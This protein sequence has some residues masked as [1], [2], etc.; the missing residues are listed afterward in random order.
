M[1]HETFEYHSG[2]DILTMG[3]VIPVM[4]I[5]RLE[6]AV[7]LASAL[8][9]GGVRV[10]EITLRTEVALK[11]IQLIRQEVEG[12]IVGAGTVMNGRQLM[13]VRAA[14]AQ[15]AISPGLTP[16]LIEKASDEGFCLIPGIATLSEL[17]LGVD[18]GLDC[19]KFF[20]AEAAGGIPMLKA[21][22]GPVPGV[23]FCPTGGI[24]PDNYLD[25]LAL[26]NVACVGGSWL[27]PKALLARGDWDSIKK[28][29]SAVSG[30]R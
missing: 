9:A 4:V 10:L 27:A 1:T 16:A 18:A 29:A 24:S 25:Y 8:V 22:L 6:E 11:A 28:L 17:M 5:H 26:D 30:V 15:F 20:P 2:R 3:P 14:G 7:P 23:T 21:I 13:E 19:F 12:A